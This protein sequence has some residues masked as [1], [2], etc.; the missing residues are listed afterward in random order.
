M[1]PPRD[2]PR[3]LG[4]NLPP[5]ATDSEIEELRLQRLAEKQKH[6]PKSDEP[7]NVH[8]NGWK[9]TVP[10]VVVAAV[11]SAFGARNIPSATPEVR[12]MDRV[13]SRQERFEQRLER[14]VY[15]NEQR[16]RQLLDE[17]QRI[18]TQ[19]TLNEQLIAQLRLEVAEAR[20]R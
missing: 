9:V 19:Q 2:P 13:E 6:V 4:A 5:R 14:Q 20:R 11:L 1:T 10:S 7:I 17:L 8:G 12:A 15:E 18:R 16:H 3:V